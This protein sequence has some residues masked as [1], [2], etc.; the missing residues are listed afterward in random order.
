MKEYPAPKGSLE[1]IV[2]RLDVE[3]TAPAITFPGSAS[4]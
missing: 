1:G 3:P 2:V 4:H